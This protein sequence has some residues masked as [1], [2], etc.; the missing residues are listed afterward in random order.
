VKRGN[1]GRVLTERAAQALWLGNREEAE[2][3]ARRAHE[4]APRDPEVL[5]TLADIA[6]ILSDTNG[7]A[8]RLE[9]AIIHHAPPAPAAWHRLLGELR[10]RQGRP[11]DAVR[12]FQA[13]LSSA[14]DDAETW[15]W[16][17]TVLRHLG[18]VATAI[19]AWRRVLALSPD[20]W[21]A[22]N[23]L[24]TALMEAGALDEADTAFC[25]AVAR[26]GD[27]PLVAMNRAT[28]QARQGRRADAIA[29]L[30]ASL[31]L[32]PDYPAAH[33]ALGF[34]L[35]D[36]RE[37]QEAAAAF[38]RAVALAPDNASA[39]CGL[40]RALL[41][42][43]FADQALAVAQAYLRRRPGHAGA[44][45]LEAL[46]RLALGDGEG[47]TR[48]LDHDR[49]VSVRTLSA[50]KEFANLPQFNAALA[51]HAA[52]HP[53]LLRAPPSHA[54]AAGLHSGSL[55]VEPRGPVAAFERALRAAIDA[56]RHAL[57]D[58]PDHPFVASR[59]Q[60]AFINMWCIVLQRGGHQIPH[61]HQDAW[62]SG[63]YYA[64]IPPSV[65]VD[66]PA[67]WLEFGDAD[68]PFPRL[69]E[70]RV[71]RVRPVE[72]LLLFFPSYF[73]HRTVPFDGDGTRISIA[74]D[75]M[76]ASAPP[77]AQTP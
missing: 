68:R 44:L 24:G 74:F 67:G 72:G 29:T 52:S 39:A 26:S 21:R 42:G 61:I 58:A 76:P 49:F 35:R 75:V 14:P 41:E 27:S 18:H 69:L 1:K 48:L 17:A 54:T 46:S 31:A 66:G 23:D 59:P 2:A 33:A 13:A 15:R 55:L 65:S 45:A 60:S 6:L 56:Y 20:D 38:R 50:P 43:G 5:H 11:G 16:L 19:Q 10:V 53:T 47:A 62:L 51:A 34:V 3:L 28:L 57:P 77:A 30:Q 71:V 73:Y 4:A 64:Q 9:A 8:K 70:P 36:Q 22:R 40:G 37:F 25:E 7:A 63:V 32:H 12:C